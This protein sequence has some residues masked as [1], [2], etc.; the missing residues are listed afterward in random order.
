MKPIN[1]KF[2]APF[3]INIQKRGGLSNL[4]KTVFDFSVLNPIER[5]VLEENLQCVHWILRLSNRDFFSVF[6]SV[7]FSFLILVELLGLK[8]VPVNYRNVTISY[9]SLICCVTLIVLILHSVMLT[10]SWSI[11]GLAQRLTSRNHA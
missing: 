3:K 4:K 5:T 2:C 7:K 8:V 11:I 9:C 10:F 6:S 1:L